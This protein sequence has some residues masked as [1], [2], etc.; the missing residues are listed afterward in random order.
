MAHRTIAHVRS[1]LAIAGSDPTGGAGVQADL[2]VFRGFGVHGAGVI[3]ALT[4]QDSVKI[5][6][7]TLFETE[8][9]YA[10]AGSIELTADDEATDG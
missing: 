4:V 9:C 10:E 2:Q 8:K 7:I 5:H 3:T 1:A 6:R